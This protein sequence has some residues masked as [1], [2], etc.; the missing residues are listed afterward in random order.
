MYRMT[1]RLVGV[2]TVLSSF[3]LF[4]LLLVVCFARPLFV[5]RG[6]AVPT[7]TLLLY[8]YYYMLKSFFCSL[9]LGVASERTARV[10]YQRAISYYYCM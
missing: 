7:L 1:A 5:A 10:P 2:R 9:L 3:L 4:F 8:F 6:V